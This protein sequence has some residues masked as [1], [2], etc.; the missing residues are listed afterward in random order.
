MKILLTVRTHGSRAFVCHAL[1]RRPPALQQVAKCRRASTRR[2]PASSSTNQGD[3]N[4]RAAPTL[5][6]EGEAPSRRCSPLSLSLS[7]SISLAHTH[8]HTHRLDGAVD[9]T[10]DNRGRGLVFGPELLPERLHRLA[11]SAPS[12]GGVQPASSS[13]RPPGPSILSR[14]SPPTRPGF[15]DPPW[16]TKNLLIT[17]PA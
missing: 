13:Q 2:I 11:V 6:L 16:Y 10:D 12:P 3:R 17:R 4:R 8:T 1:S 15:L 5:M 7:L 9:V 14:M